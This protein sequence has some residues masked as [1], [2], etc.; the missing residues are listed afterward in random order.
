V[1]AGWGKLPWFHSWTCGTLRSTLGR[2]AV[3]LKPFSPTLDVTCQ[4]IIRYVSFP[5]I[6]YKKGRVNDLFGHIS[7]VAQVLYIV[8]R[9]VSTTRRTVWRLI[10]LKLTTECDRMKFRQV[11]LSQ[12][13]IKHSMTIVLKIIDKFIPFEQST[14][15]SE[16]SN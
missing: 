4:K 12:S 1:N 16:R 2:K 15:H 5:H 8:Q 7:T 14:F 11:L 13:I 6:A 3:Y 9:R 10:I